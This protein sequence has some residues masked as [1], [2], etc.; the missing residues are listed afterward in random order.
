[1]VRPPAIDDEALIKQTLQRYRNAYA[2]L[3]A[4]SAQA[5][6]PAVNEG[7]LARAF[8]GLQSQSLTF[9][10]CAVHLSDDEATATCHGSA[11]Y[12]AKIGSREPRVEPRV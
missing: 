6:W 11:E 2:D 10:V 12:V 8:D 5:V 3:D 4:R 9:D 1:V 7:A